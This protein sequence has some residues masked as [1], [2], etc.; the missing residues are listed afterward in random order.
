MKHTLLYLLL[1]ILLCTACSDALSD[2]E[3]FDRSNYQ[4]SIALPV[5]HGKLSFVDLLDQEDNSSFFT[6]EEDKL[7][8]NYKGDLARQSSLDIFEET[9]NL[10][11]FAPDTLN[12]VPL[13]FF[14][15]VLL[16]YAS[17]SGGTMSVLSRNDYEEDIMVELSL[18]ELSY[19]ETGEEFKA[20]YGPFEDGKA[21]AINQDLARINLNLSKNEMELRIVGILPDGKRVPLPSS[22]VGALRNMTFSYVEGY[23]EYEEI[24]I[25]RD[26][27]EIEIFQ[28]LRRGDLFFEDPEI[29]VTI[30]NSFGFPV[31]SDIKAMELY[32]LNGVT[33]PV[34]S[35]FVENGFDIAFPLAIGEYA[36]TVFNFDKNNSNLQEI[37]SIKPKALFYDM[38]A[39]SNPDRDTS[40]IG[41]MT[42]SSEFIVQVEVRLPL[43]GS[44]KDFEVQDT[45]D[46][47]LPVVE[48]AQ[49]D[50]GE[51]KLILDNQ[52]PL[53]VA[54]QLYLIDDNDMI[55]DS[56]FNEETVI[57]S[58]RN[59]VVNTFLIP[60][61]KERYEKWKLA[62]RV[63]S[64][65][66]F[67][68]VDY[69]NSVA[70][71]A[72]DFIE[73]KMGLIAHLSNLE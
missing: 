45:F 26:T 52:M 66:K 4:P 64:L 35:P 37:T 23:W 54:T 1:C 6:L 55:I 47:E 41:F 60:F 17:L 49:V 8:F 2:I 73:L 7:I 70:V 36:S 9:T 29:K 62:N 40:R 51:V 21:V 63:V 44:A 28:T 65:A 32:D 25:D 50:S 22:T 19:D 16:R 24:P 58:N 14:N 57:L 53:D 12:I 30:N 67:S 69:P 68:T 43:E 48:G 56:L 34:E 33:Y 10:P 59:E 38:F 15:N 20:L 42:D 31:R 61:D 3:D 72:S 71:Y 27:I 18:P 39:I 13:N 46:F 5:A 11:F